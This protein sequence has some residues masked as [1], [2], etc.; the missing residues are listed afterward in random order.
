MRNKDYEQRIGFDENVDY[1]VVI[2]EYNKAVEEG[3]QEEAIR[4]INDQRGLINL[5]LKD[6]YQRV[7]IKG[8]DCKIINPKLKQYV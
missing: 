5:C 2:A 6:H 4:I 1:S 8:E 7:E 3:N